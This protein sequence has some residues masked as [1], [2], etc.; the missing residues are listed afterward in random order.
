MM[1]TTS[2]VT[3][4]LEGVGGGVTRG[5]DC[6]AVWDNDLRGEVRREDSCKVRS[7]LLGEES[8]ARNLP[9]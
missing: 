5:G 2:T 7:P 9:A 3:S 6:Y 8:L 4:W 1:R